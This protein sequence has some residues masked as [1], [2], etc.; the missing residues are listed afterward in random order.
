MNCAV[1]YT[2]LCDEIDEQLITI[3]KVSKEYIEKRETFLELWRDV[4]K[5]AL[6]L[7]NRESLI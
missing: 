2:K 4:G 7:M 6:A 1:E 5:M 3:L